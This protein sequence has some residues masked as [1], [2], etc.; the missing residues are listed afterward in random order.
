MV[1]RSENYP[2]VSPLYRYTRAVATE[3]RDDLQSIS[4]VP[5]TDRSPVL[6]A[7]NMR[8][9]HT[10]HPLKA[11]PIYSIAFISDN[12]VILGGGGGSS[13]AGIKNKMVRLTSCGGSSRHDVALN[14]RNYFV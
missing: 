14:C 11:F 8:A 2:R 3:Y 1:V 9:K 12:E 10:S 5:T 7:S 4:H 13:R 6:P